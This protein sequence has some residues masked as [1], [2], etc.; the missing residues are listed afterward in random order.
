[1]F[2]GRHR[3]PRNLQIIKLKLHSSFES[4]KTFRGFKK[5]PSI[6]LGRISVPDPTLDLAYYGIRRWLLLGAHAYLLA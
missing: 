1:M 3:S 6:L 5:I 2:N 4:K